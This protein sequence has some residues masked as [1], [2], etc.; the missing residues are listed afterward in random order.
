MQKF[1]SKFHLSR[2]EL[3]G[4]FV[5]SLILILSTK[6]PFAKVEGSRGYFTLFDFAAPTTLAFLG[7]IP[8]IIAIAIVQIANIILNGTQQID[9]V[10]IVRL[11]PIFFGAIYFQQKN[12]TNIL[13]PIAAIILFILNPIG[14]Q[15]WYYALFWTIPLFAYVLRNRFVFA[16]ALGATFTQHAVG[17]V[18]W[19]YLIPTTA[20]YWNKLIPLV[21]S[22]RLMIAIGMVAFFV[23]F[24]ELINFMK[25]KKIISLNIFDRKEN[26]SDKI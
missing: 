19:L 21:L 18:L 20:D 16:R 13:L 15:V 1:L 10:A 9:A 14:Q 17:G 24:K 7:T 23:F 2:K 8:G 6:I 5:F 26:Y 11:F 3:I 4:I 25:E 22:E 12:K